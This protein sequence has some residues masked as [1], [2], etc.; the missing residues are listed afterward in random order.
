MSP[1]E[2]PTDEALAD[3]IRE[4]WIAH[5]VGRADIMNLQTHL[6]LRMIEQGC[7]SMHTP[8]DTRAKFVFS[9]H[10]GSPRA[11][12]LRRQQYINSGLPFT[13]VEML[14]RLQVYRERKAHKWDQ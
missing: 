11:R 7:Y 9:S 3:A 10:P 2:F 1:N 4:K 13:E 6:E 5:A 12:R 8:G 14:P